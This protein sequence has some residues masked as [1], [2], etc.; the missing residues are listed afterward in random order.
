MAGS[1]QIMSGH[2][3]AGET[4]SVS[5]LTPADI[6][7]YH[8]FDMAGVFWAFSYDVRGIPLAAFG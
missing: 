8:N 4:A 3:D 2:N 7:A 1:C 5:T 6:T